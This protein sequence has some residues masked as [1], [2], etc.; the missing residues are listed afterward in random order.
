VI[1]KIC[2]ALILAL[3]VGATASAA[4]RGAD[5]RPLTVEE[6]IDDAEHALDSGRFG[7]AE[8][9]EARLR[10]S[11]LTKEEHDR[12]ELITARCALAAGKYDASEK[13]FGKLWKHSPEDA[14]VA[15]WYAQAL[16]GSGKDAQ[17]LDLLDKLAA[18]DGLHEGDSYW[19]LAQLERTNG[20]Q[21]DALRHARLALDKPFVF[22]S[23]E[24]ETAIKRFIE[25]L[26]EQPKKK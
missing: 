11:H 13:L 20:R 26:T 18:K 22:Q 5:E 1:P 15:E 19:T 9:E 4:P 25:E 2:P 8:R 10:R 17:A 6:A 12:L 23:I 3:A 21:A 24:T 7:D 14:R 16:A